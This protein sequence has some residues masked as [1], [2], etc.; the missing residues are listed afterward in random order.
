MNEKYISMQKKNIKLRAF[1][2]LLGLILSMNYFLYT[3]NK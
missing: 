1:L 3:N 2:I